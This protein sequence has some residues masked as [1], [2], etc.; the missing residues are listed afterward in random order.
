MARHGSSSTIRP[1]TTRHTSIDPLC[2]IELIAGEE[3]TRC[4]GADA[5]SGIAA[6]RSRASSRSWRGDPE[7]ARLLLDVRRT[8]EAGAA[9][10]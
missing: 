7:V 1:C 10:A 2:T 4:P 5:H 6:A 8:L 3:A 9:A